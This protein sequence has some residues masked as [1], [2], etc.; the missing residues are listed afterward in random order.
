MLQ[1]RQE[2][3]LQTNVQLHRVGQQMLEGVMRPHMA[4]LFIVVVKQSLRHKRCGSVNG[5]WKR[6]TTESC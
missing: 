6:S 4:M 3:R 1:R 2:L 5:K